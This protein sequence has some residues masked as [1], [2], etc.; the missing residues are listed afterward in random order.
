MNPKFLFISLS[1]IFIGFSISVYL[2]PLKQHEKNKFNK[3]EAVQGRLIWQENN[4]HVCHQLY[5]LGGFLGPDLTN[6]YAKFNENEELLKMFFKGGIKQMPNYSFSQKESK[7]LI[8]FLK[9]CNQSGIA[10]PRKM[11]IYTNGMIEHDGNNK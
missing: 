3:W 9:Q 6:V 1:I 4:C 7:L 10:D 2:M 5:G 11:T 8:E